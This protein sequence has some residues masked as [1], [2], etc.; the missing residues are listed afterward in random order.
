MSSRP[1]LLFLVS[2]DWYFWGHRIGLARAAREHRF[3]VSVATRVGQLGGKIE[4]EGFKLLP[5]RL[6]RGGQ[7]PVIDFVSVLEL[8][9]LYRREQP[10]IVHH[11]G[12]KAAIYGAW[13]ARCS[14][15]PSMVVT[16]PGLGHTFSAGDSRARTMRLAVGQALR[17]SLRHRNMRAIFQNV[18]DQNDLVREGIVRS[19]DARLIRGSG[20][21]V[22]RFV[23]SEETPG[24]PVVILAS[25][26]L[27]S[28]GVGEFVEAARLLKK[29]G[30]RAR[31]VLSGR[32]DT[33]NPGGIPEEQLA[34]WQA[35]GVVDWWAYRED[36]PRV[37]AETHIVVLPTYYGEGVP[38]VL[39]EAASSGRPIVATS[40]R[41]CREIVRDGENGLLVPARDPVALA[42]AIA[43]LVGDPVLRSKMGTRGRQIV[44]DEFS[45]KHVNA[46]T[47]AVYQELL[48]DRWP[49]SGAGQPA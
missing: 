21:D 15:V 28:K 34:T 2:E 5:I 6:S 44:I 30:V 8:I 12:M 17:W 3:S 25:R 9:R 26:M 42:D 43:T 23:P 45:M 10:D 49:A 32:V 47:L 31:Y 36:M 48:G 39:I 11:I 7:N 24:D 33:E 40:E 1:K 41:G 13:A 4:G 27:W 46:K 37:F 35:E 18:D 14:S 19:E 22:S 29:R 20:V 38:K 16:F